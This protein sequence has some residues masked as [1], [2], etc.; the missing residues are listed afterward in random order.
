VK[1]VEGEAVKR[2]WL[3]VVLGC[4]VPRD[5]IAEAAQASGF[6]RHVVYKALDRGELAASVVC[7]ER[8]GVRKASIADGLRSLLP[9]AA[10]DQQ[11]RNA[12]RHETGR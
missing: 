4:G 6:S 9:A 10:R 12:M 7:G 8:I 11:L 3:E 5:L 1:R 2:A